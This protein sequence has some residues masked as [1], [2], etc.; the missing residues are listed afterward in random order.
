VLVLRWCPT[1]EMKRAACVGRPF[2]VSVWRTLSENTVFLLLLVIVI[3]VQLALLWRSFPLAA[4]LSDVPLL[5]VDMAFHWYQVSVAGALWKEG[6]V[7]GFDPWFAAGHIGGIPYNASAKVPALI[8]A[9]MPHWFSAASAY[10]AYCVLTAILSPACVV[11]ALR[12][13][14]AD[15]LSLAVGA[16]FGVLMFWVSALRWYYSVG[17]VSYVLAAFLALPYVALLWRAVVEP[18]R[19]WTIPTLIVIGALGLFNHPL[20]ALPVLLSAPF[21]VAAYFADL[22]WRQVVV[23]IALV[24]ALTFIISLPWI[25][26]TVHLPGWSDTSLSPYQKAVDG[27]I[28]WD[29]LLG[30]IT[31]HARGARINSIVMLSTFVALASVSGKGPR[32]QHIVHGGAACAMLIF[33]SFGALSPVVAT[34]QPNRLSTAAFLFLAIPASYG[35]AWMLR[36]TLQRQNSVVLRAG[37]GLALLAAI[38][39]PARELFLELS[40]ANVPRHGRPAPEVTGPGELTRWLEQWLLENTTDDGRVL[41]E[42]SLG[43]IYDGGHVAGYLAIRTQREFIGGPYVFMHHAGFWDGHL[44]GLPIEQLSANDW[45][46]RF[47]LYNIKWVIV[48]SLKSRVALADLPQITLRATHGPVSIFEVAGQSSYFL[49]GSGR[50]SARRWNRVEVTDIVGAPVIL[51]YHYVPGLHT[52]PATRIEPTYL[53]G[54][55]SPFVLLP[56]PPKSVIIKMD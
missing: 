53:L 33:A 25:L 24:P 31:V 44:F 14:R 48:H 6:R 10:K 16:V 32:R 47:K 56:E 21:I 50:V 46:A 17:M 51:K 37:L 19:W 13:W 39:I 3:A 5:N 20:F 15:S 23:V 54:D 29:E 28:I 34:L 4:V 7:V 43:R 27:K 11:V 30:R 55:P 49:Q 8:A 52:E 40:A 42:T 12:M 45:V 36:T 18:L 26:P 41:F 1:V 9:M 2:P 35:W 22:Q 38:G